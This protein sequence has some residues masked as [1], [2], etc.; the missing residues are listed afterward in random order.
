[1]TLDQ[2]TTWAQIAL[3]LVTSLAWIKEKR[4]AA[5]AEASLKIWRGV[6]L[7][8]IAALAVVMLKNKSEKEGGQP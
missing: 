4:R 6:A 2:I 5:H 3:S 1:M 7:A 8:S